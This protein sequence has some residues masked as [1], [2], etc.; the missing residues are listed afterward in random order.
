MIP[1]AGLRVIMVLRERSQGGPLFTYIKFFVVF[2]LWNLTSSILFF[3][4]IL[5]LFTSLQNTLLVLKPVWIL[6]HIF[7]LHILLPV[8]GAPQH[9]KRIITASVVVAPLRLLFGGFGHHSRRY[10]G[11][12]IHGGLQ[13]VATANVT[14]FSGISVR[15]WTFNWIES[16]I[17]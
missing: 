10:F 15:K 1:E 11:G 13:S 14:S 4:I 12:G 6:P 16:Q 3:C 5:I 8:K 9:G 17:R 2:E 7:P